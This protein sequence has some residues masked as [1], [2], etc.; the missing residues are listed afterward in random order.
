MCGFFKVNITY[1]L[2][3]EKISIL[4]REV[5]YF[6]FSLSIP[7]DTFHGGQHKTAASFGGKE[8]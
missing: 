2:L 4:V 5:R 6:G 8:T 1:R 7:E 3:L